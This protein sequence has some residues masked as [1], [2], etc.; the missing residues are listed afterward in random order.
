MKLSGIAI[1]N[2]SEMSS[3]TE[4]GQKI[5]QLWIVVTFLVVLVINLL[6][7]YFKKLTHIQKIYFLVI[8]LFY[9]IFQI[10]LGNRRE[11]ATILFFICSYY[12]VYKRNV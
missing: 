10:S 6:V 2:F 9:F 8:V 4:L 5:S 3:R 11:I 7:F 1:F 12:L